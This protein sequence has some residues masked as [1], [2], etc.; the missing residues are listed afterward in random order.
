METETTV[1]LYSSEKALVAQARLGAY[2]S[3]HVFLKD[4]IASGGQL[5][6]TMTNVTDITTEAIVSDKDWGKPIPGR[7]NQ[8]LLLVCI[9]NLEAP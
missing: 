2:V 6:A 5:I 4:L 3:A 7:A 8:V 9:S 1:G